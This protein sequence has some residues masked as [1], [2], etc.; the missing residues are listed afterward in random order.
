M[1]RLFSL[2]GFL[3]FLLAISAISCKKE[4]TNDNPLIGKWNAVSS[5][6]T[7]YENNVKTDEE[8]V[9]FLQGE[10][11]MEFL[12]DGKGKTYTNGNLAGT[13]DWEVDGDQ[14]LL[15]FNGTSHMEA[16]FTI[17]GNT[18]TVKATWEETSDSVVYKTVSDA[19]YSRT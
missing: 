8:T 9:N 12:A 3:F 13:F 5:K 14:L 19:V 17:N 2:T 11:A 1:S 6:I 18:M 10:S 7:Y 4:K 16:K 15:T